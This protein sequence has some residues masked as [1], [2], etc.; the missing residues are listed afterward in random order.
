MQ[1]LGA[2]AP[3]PLEEDNLKSWV[4]DLETKLEHEYNKQLEI[5]NKT[6]ELELSNM[7]LSNDLKSFESSKVKLN[8][9]EMIFAICYQI[10]GSVVMAEDNENVDDDGTLLLNTLARPHGLGARALIENDGPYQS[11]MKK[12]IILETHE[13]G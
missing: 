5:I 6:H 13:N 10:A 9:L 8:E 1:Q 4:K 11:T 7:K 2:M 3:D 12:A